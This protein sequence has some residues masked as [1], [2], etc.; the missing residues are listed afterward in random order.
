MISSAVI[1]HGQA[2][3]FKDC[4]LNQYWYILRKIPNPTFYVCVEEN[5]QATDMN[6]LRTRFKDVAVT[7]FIRPDMVKMF[8]PKLILHSGSGF[9]PGAENL[10]RGMYARQMAW[11]FFSRMDK[12]GHHQIVMMRPDAFLRSII[13]PPAPLPNQMFTNWWT[14]SGGVNDRIAFAGRDAA[15]A[16]FNIY[17]N[18]EAILDMGCPLDG[19]PMIEAAL[20][21]A[22]CYATPTLKMW[23]K[24][25]R[26]DGSV[27]EPEF[28]TDEMVMAAHGV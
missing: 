13:I 20:E 27:S 28:S 25:R 6:L 21:M 26:L 14:R 23:C 11:E 7:T 1:Y 17:D 10:M 9:N 3:T 18:A 2:R 12:G 22:G 5:E 8:D 24:M 15:K 19:E 4:F 16:V